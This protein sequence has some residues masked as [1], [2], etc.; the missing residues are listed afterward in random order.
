MPN[1][2]KRSAD[3]KN[4]T[5]QLASKCITMTIT[6]IISVDAVFLIMAETEDAFTAYSQTNYLYRHQSKMPSS[7]KMTHKW[8]FAAGAYQSL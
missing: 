5:I 6:I 2:L 4:Q 1:E 8:D 7:K 3:K